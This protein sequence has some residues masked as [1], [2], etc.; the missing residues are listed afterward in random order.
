MTPEVLQDIPRV[1]TALAEW[2]ACVVYITLAPKRLHRGSLVT[3][4]GAGLVVLIGVQELAGALPIGLWSLGM[5]LAAASMYLLI[6]ATTDTDS[7]GAGD[8]L[9]RAFVLAELV[10]SLEWQL[11]QHFFGGAEWTMGRFALVPVIFG[12]AFTGA[13][14]AERRNFPPGRHISVDGR[15]LS[16]TLSIALVTFLMSNL[17]FVTGATP[18]SASEGREIFYIRTLVDL[19]GFIALYAMRSQRLQLQRAV[20]VQSMN[21]LLRSQH[22]QYERSRRER[23][24]VNARYHDLKHYIAAIRTETDDHARSGMV[25]RLEESIRG[26]G[27]AAVDT[28]N[29]VVDTML[30][31]KLA[32][33]EH[34]G[35][36][37]TCVVDGT[38]VEFMEVMDLVTVFGNAM[39]N[40]IEATGRVAAKDRRLLRVAVNRQGHFAVLRFENYFGGRLTLVDGLPPT[41]KDDAHHHGYG[42]KNMRQAV[43]R[44]DGSFTVAAEDGWFVLRMLVPIPSEEG[45]MRRAADRARTAAGGARGEPEAAHRR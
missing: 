42:L 28:G 30:S 12:L 23:E 24:A 25:D 40:A 5:I 32:E 35:I 33:A 11:D 34:A 21:T 43:E 19:A 27:A 29:G 7:K 36:T 41:T 8:L 38:A 22:E 37:A 3:T 45:T 26:Y 1:L 4:L 13:W 20:E 2:S 18:F 44:Y 31:T 10:A 39:D 9:A 17:S 15:I 16:S 14:F 6:W